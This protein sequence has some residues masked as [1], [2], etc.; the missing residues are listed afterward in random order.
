M[1]KKARIKRLSHQDDVKR[2]WSATY[3]LEEF[4]LALPSEEADLKSDENLPAQAE[5]QEDIEQAEAS[6]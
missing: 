4:E 5:P 1:E 2:S 3:Q 6:S